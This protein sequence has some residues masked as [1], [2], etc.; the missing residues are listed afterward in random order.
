MTDEQKPPR[1]PPPVNLDQLFSLVTRAIRSHTNA[2]RLLDAK[3]VAT[4]KAEGEI[5]SALSSQRERQSGDADLIRERVDLALEVARDARDAIREVLR[6]LRDQ[7]HDI[8]QVEDRLA[9]KLEQLGDRFT[10]QSVPLLPANQTGPVPVLV[11]DHEEKLKRTIGAAVVELGKRAL[12]HALKAVGAGLGAGTA[13][14]ALEAIR[15]AL[16]W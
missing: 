15:H 11:E 4:A 13:Y 16:G 1:P 9:D 12:P 14:K 5:L 2:I 3:V 6:V 10:P 7:G 8:G